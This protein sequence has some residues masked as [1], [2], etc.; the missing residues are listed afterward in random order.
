M[1]SRC[2]P[3]SGTLA[4]SG[5]RRAYAIPLPAARGDLAAYLR[6]GVPESM[7][8]HKDVGMSATIQGLVSDVRSMGFSI[9]TATA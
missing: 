8:G 1:G 6:S 7:G 4:E 9:S 5:L 2:Y 3:A